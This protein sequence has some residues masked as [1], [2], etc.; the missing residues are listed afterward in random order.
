MHII[1]ILI[2]I[3]DYLNH[4]LMTRR[5]TPPPS[6]SGTEHYRREH[7]SV[8]SRRSAHQHKDRR[9]ENGRPAHHQGPAPEH[10]LRSASDAGHHPL[11]YPLCD[12]APLS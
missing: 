7:A 2:R 6:R 4:N 9:T 5:N 12:I 11:R 8:D 3:L 10:R 1:N